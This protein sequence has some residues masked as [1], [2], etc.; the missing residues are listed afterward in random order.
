M[1]VIRSPTRIF[2][3]RGNAPPATSVRDN[4]PLA[5]AG[6]GMKGTPMKA[7]TPIQ[8]TLATNVPPANPNASDRKVR[9]PRQSMPPPTNQTD[10]PTARFQQKT[11]QIK[12]DVMRE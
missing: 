3:R 1:F 4:A 5:R 12:R 9:G 2:T 11:G 7:N 10:D 6:D 8:G